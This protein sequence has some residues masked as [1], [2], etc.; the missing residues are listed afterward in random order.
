MIA[1]DSPTMSLPRRAGAMRLEH[2]GPRQSGRRDSCC[3]RP[4]AKGPIRVCR[5][6]S[7]RLRGRA[8]SGDRALLG[9]TAPAP[10]NPRAEKQIALACAAILFRRPAMAQAGNFQSCVRD[11]SVFRRECGGVRS[12][13]NNSCGLRVGRWSGEIQPFAVR[14][15]L[16]RDPPH[17]PKDRRARL[18]RGAVLSARV[19][20]WKI[21]L[22]VLGLGSSV[23]GV[24]GA[25]GHAVPP[26]LMPKTEDLRPQYG[27]HFKLTRDPPKN[28]SPR[29]SAGGAPRGR[30]RYRPSHGR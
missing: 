2:G 18:C 30:L 25:T 17:T 11:I 23:S 20:T 16:Q 8:R 13:S 1:L 15:S 3:A 7:R 4:F 19:A 10:R 12:P 14:P 28:T 24:S 9:R 27:P 6:P 21:R 22:W 5:R 26:P 29:E